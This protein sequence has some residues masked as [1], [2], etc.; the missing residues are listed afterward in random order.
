MDGRTSVMYV[1]YYDYVKEKLAYKNTTYS[2]TSKICFRAHYYN[3]NMYI[4]NNIIS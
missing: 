3:I 1:F 2:N 4:I